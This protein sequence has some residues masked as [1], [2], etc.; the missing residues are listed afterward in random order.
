MYIPEFICGL[1]LGAIGGIALLIIIAIF[2][3][4]RR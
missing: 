4:D 1:I 2:W 3:Q